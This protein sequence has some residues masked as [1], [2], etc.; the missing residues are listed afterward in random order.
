MPDNGQSDQHNPQ[1]QPMPVNLY[2]L[3]APSVNRFFGMFAPNGVARMI[4]VDQVANTAHARCALTIHMDD[5][6]QVRNVM[7]ELIEKFQESRVK[8]N[9]EFL[10]HMKVQ[11][12]K[13]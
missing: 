3:P 11:A 12:E 8:A 1:T 7:S 2:D 4:F 10:D 9:D 6:V 5:M 13:K